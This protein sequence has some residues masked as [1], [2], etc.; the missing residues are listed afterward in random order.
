MIA[1]KAPDLW[2]LLDGPMADRRSAD[3]GSAVDLD[4][5]PALSVLGFFDGIY[6]IVRDMPAGARLSAGRCN[7]DLTWSLLPDELDSLQILLPD[8]ETGETLLTVS[9]VT[10][11]P[12]GYDFAF[13]V[14]Q[15][16]VVVKDGVSN[17]PFNS[18]RRLDASSSGGWP[19]MVR[20]ARSTHTV[21]GQ[22][23]VA[24]H[25]AIAAPDYDARLSAARAEWV[26]DEEI[27]LARARGRWE[28]EAEA[29]WAQRA[30]RLAE[31]R[32]RELRDSEIRW[33]E[34]ESERAAVAEAL[35]SAR[36]AA[37]EIHWRS[38][39]SDR[40]AAALAQR[41]RARAE[42]LRRAAGWLL[43]AIVIGSMVLA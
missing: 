4:L 25:Q 7:G 9:I 16:S 2:T 33:Q 36:L 6:L 10:P 18:I 12:L 22:P 35:W 13:T 8:A 34:R 40:F 26:A 24:M 15:F 17:I 27:R 30:A 1:A 21:R 31:A 42:R 41:T 20:R 3:R 5:H 14:A 32:D 11:D 37:A 23:P 39:E 19:G 29:I 38:E 28:A 43:F